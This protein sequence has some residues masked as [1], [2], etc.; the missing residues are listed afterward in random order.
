MVV[1][2]QGALLTLDP[3]ASTA[4]EQVSHCVSLPHLQS[5]PHFEQQQPAGRLP[6]DGDDVL[7][8]E[9]PE[10]EADPPD[11]L[12]EMVSAGPLQV[13][14]EAARPEGNVV[15]ADGDAQGLRHRVDVPGVDSDGG[16]ERRGAADELRDHDDAPPRAALRRRSRAPLPADGVLVGHQVHA[17]PHG[18]DHAALSDGVEGDPLVGG[19]PPV[20]EDNRVVPWNGEAAVYLIGDGDHLVQQFLHLLPAAPRRVGDLDED[21]SS[22]PFWELEADALE[23]ID[24]VDAQEHRPAV[25]LLHQLAGL[26]AGRRRPHNRLQ[27]PNVH[28]DREDLDAD[29]PPVVFE[30]DEPSL[31]PVVDPQ[32]PAAAGEEMAG[33]IEGVE[34]DHVGVEQRL[35]DLLPNGKRPVDLRGGEGGVEEEAELDAVKPAAEEGGENQ[36]M[37]V[38]DPDVVLV[39]VKDLRHLVGEGLV[40]GDVGLP[41]GA[42]EAGGAGGGGDRL[43]VVEQRPE[44]ALA[45][46]VTGTQRNFSYRTGSWLVT[47]IRRSRGGE[48]Q[49]PATKGGTGSSE[50]W[51]VAPPIPPE[52]EM[53]PGTVT[54]RERRGFSGLVGEAKSTAV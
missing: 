15:G 23:Q 7:H 31:G 4:G 54:A 51:P 47:M 50:E 33:V 39:G 53:M 28:A 52:S 32:H 19:Q 1:P 37:V 5:I 44:V 14:V 6:V 13:P 41:E 10:A 3:R 21:R 46:A 38:V 2:D 20:D 48:S 40:G 45:E 26:L 42:V 22:P 12:E 35:E 30:A 16:A 49:A 25:E 43:R 24:V 9:L 29:D 8:R 17:V 11:P 18:V 34:A 36:Q 27:L